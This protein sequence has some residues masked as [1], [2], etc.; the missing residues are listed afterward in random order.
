MS[1]AKIVRIPILP[2]HIVNAY[3]V[4]GDGG[5]VLV[6]A[7]TPGSEGAIERVLGANGLSW[8]DLRAIIVT[9]AH[10]D[11]AG[12]AAAVRERSG[13][14]LVAHRDDRPFLTGI[15]P[16]T[17]CPTGWAGRVFVRS[18]RP[19]QRY[20]PVVADLELSGDETLDLTR[21]G[22]EGTV[23]H[24]AGHTPG[25]LVV[26]LPSGDALVSD[27]LASGIFIGGILRLGHAI[28]PPFEDDPST[29]ATALERLVD[30]GMKKFY[31][32]HGGPLDAREVMRHARALR[33]APRG[34]PQL[35]RNADRVIASP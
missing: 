13:A 18:K 15:K 30:T 32:G 33:N 2:A 10:A 3:L 34:A 1:T 9:H 19:H 29:V 24:T 6:D 31:L 7:G 27:L 23:Q 28:R 12:S 14:T 20:T 8:R 17:F 5:C 16:I 35:Q 22:V 21:F 11:H 4:V 25:S 26:T